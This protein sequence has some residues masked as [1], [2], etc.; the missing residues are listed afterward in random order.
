MCKKPN[1]AYNSLVLPARKPD[2]KP[3]PFLQG[4]PDCPNCRRM[5]KVRRHY[6]MCPAELAEL[7]G[8]PDRVPN[9]N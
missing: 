7:A 1:L 6:N 4:I 5:N 8:L 2:R 9:G 3:I